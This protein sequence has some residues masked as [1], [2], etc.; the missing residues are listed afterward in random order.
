MNATSKALG[1]SAGL[2]V[3]I[4]WRDEADGS[5][6]SLFPSWLPPW[7]GSETLFAWCSRYHKIAGHRLSSV[8]AQRLF[9]NARAGISHD[10]PGHLGE[11]CLRTRGV[12][13]SLPELVMN[14]TILGYYMSL[15]SVEARG[16]VIE[17]LQVANAGSLKAK[18]GWLATRLGA[19]HPL[20]ACDECITAQKRQEPGPS[21]ILAHQPPGV[22]RCE[23]H[24]V[25]LWFTPSIARTAT[26]RWLLPEG[27]QRSDRMASPACDP[28]L[29]REVAVSTQNLLNLTAK[30]PFDR[31][32]VANAFLGQL[33]SRRLASNGRLRARE[34]GEAYSSFLSCF[35]GWPE[36][37]ALCVSTAGAEAALRRILDPN[38]NVHPLR[39]IAA[40][41]WLYGSWSEF[42][43]SYSKA[44]STAP[45]QQRSSIAKGPAPGR[46]LPA[47]KHEEVVNA[48]TRDGASVR[49]AARQAGVSIGTAL[50]WAQQQGIATSSRAKTLTPLI[51]ASAV[52]HLLAGEPKEA[53]ASSLSI[54]VQSVTRILLGTPGLKQRRDD[55]LFAKRQKEARAAW[56][57]CLRLPGGG[58]TL[59]NR[60]PAA[61]AWLYR[62][63][64]NW[65]AQHLPDRA[66]SVRVQRVDWKKRDRELAEQLEELAAAHG[67]KFRSGVEVMRAFP[68]LSRKVDQ[69]ARLPRTM[70]VMAAVIAAR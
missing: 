57:R 22:W 4:G 12:L 17:Q 51:R 19:A 31:R 16:I 27:L 34:C 15:R 52:K 65:L 49:S 24:D 55:L 63:D 37:D 42:S 45:S 5:D 25:P 28:A 2:L 58:S 36:S 35:S 43:S 48:I 70:K 41:L 67:G 18:L 29:A 3:G 13:G 66:E 7:N 46:P 60:Q 64:R 50:L 9:G 69:I 32:R 54:S 59:R 21:W 53:I 30:D 47:S 11:F 20:K 56:L 6:D 68:S 10:L 62:N 23:K 33:E 26:S 38:E 1:D 39:L 44:G 8:T 61:Y 14:R 40:V